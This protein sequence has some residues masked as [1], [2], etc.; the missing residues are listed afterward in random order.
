MTPE[1]EKE[2]VRKLS[3]S[4]IK[5]IGALD[6]AAG[7]FRRLTDAV[8]MFRKAAQ[9]AEHRARKANAKT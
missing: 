7:S 9:N 3:L 2:M 6:A 8:K 4:G 1:Q 5:L